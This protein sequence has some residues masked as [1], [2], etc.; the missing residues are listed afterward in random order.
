MYLVFVL[1]EQQVEGENLS[2]AKSLGIALHKLLRNGV[3]NS[4]HFTLQFLEPFGGGGK[5]E[6]AD[7]ILGMIDLRFVPKL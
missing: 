7:N 3:L 4:G 5:D 6:E 2:G 1:S